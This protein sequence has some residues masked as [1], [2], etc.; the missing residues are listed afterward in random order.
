MLASPN[1]GRLKRFD[2]FGH[3]YVTEYSLRAFAVTI[4]KPGGQT[5]FKL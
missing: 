3:P 2:F 5:R 1:N 4:R